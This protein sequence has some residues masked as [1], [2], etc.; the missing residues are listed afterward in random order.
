MRNKLIAACMALAAFAAFAVLPAAA[1]AKNTPVLVEG[2]K[3]PLAV[4]AKIVGTN[5]NEATFTSG[6]VTVHCNKAEMTGTLTKN[7]TGSVEGSI[8]AAHFT[9]T[10]ANGDCTSNLG[11][12]NVIEGPATNGLP[13]CLRSTETMGTDEFQV[14][15]NECS[16][17]T[18]PIRFELQF[19]SAGTTCAYERSTAISGT[20]TTHPSEA[21]LTI[22]EVSFTKVG[23]SFLCPSTGGLDMAFRLE[24]H[25]GTPLYIEA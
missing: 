1:S 12:V 7:V 19:T 13:W 21:V 16:K 8:T 9:G 24:T 15:G 22:K 5:V 18:R 3:S 23:G 2:T 20:Y 11:D 6:G 25:N 17:A 14:R 10:G 4:G